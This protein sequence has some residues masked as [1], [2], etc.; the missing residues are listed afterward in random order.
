M[1]LKRHKLNELQLSADPQPQ[2][3]DP[4]AEASRVVSAASLRCVEL[5]QQE[6]EWTQKRT[7]AYLEFCAALE[8]Y[9]AAKSGLPV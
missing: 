9:Q 6:R 1:F 3:G 7:Q 5:D 4:V 8:K 2:V